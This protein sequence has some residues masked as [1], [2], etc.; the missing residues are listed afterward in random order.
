M[1]FGRVPCSRYSRCSLEVYGNALVSSSVYCLSSAE[2]L[3]NSAE[4]YS[5]NTRFVL[6]SLLVTSYILSSL[7]VEM[8]FQPA[9]SS[10]A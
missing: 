7:L 1:Y 8:N 2:S 10:T 5:F 3:L 6:A 9:L 4:A